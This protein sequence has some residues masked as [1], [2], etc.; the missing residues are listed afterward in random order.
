MTIQDYEVLC[1][2]T[3][4]RTLQRDLRGLVDKGLLVERGTSPTDPTKRYVLSGSL[5]R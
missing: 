3:N 1:P 2:D 5:K 4:R